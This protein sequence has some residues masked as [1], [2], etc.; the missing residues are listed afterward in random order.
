MLP[1]ALFDACSAGVVIPS[2]LNHAYK[3]VRATPQLSTQHLSFQLVQV[4]LCSAFAG[5]QPAMHL[6]R[7]GTRAWRLQSRN[8]V[9]LACTDLSAIIY[10]DVQGKA[11]S[12]LLWLLDLK[13]FS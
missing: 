7:R 2:F 1:G 6:R 11:I 10:L 13:L 5:V 3:A 12:N 4:L 9:R 8:A